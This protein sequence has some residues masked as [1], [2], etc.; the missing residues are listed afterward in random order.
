MKR[1]TL[2]SFILCGLMIQN[3]SNAQQ[4]EYY[5]VG[6]TI[7]GRSP[8]YYYQWWSEAW[9]ADTSHRINAQRSYGIRFVESSN[10]FHGEQLQYYY[11][12]TPIQIIGIATSCRT[13]PLHAG[14]VDFN[15]DPLYPEYLRLYDATVDDFVLLEE[16]QFQR[17]TPKRYMNIDIRV[18]PG[19]YND[20]CYIESP[21]TIVTVDIREYYFEK[22]VTVT[23]SFYV[24]H[25]NENSYGYSYDI[26]RETIDIKGITIEPWA[27]AWDESRITRICDH[28]CGSTPNHLKKYR[29]IVWNTQPN[30]PTYGDTIASLSTWK[31][32]EDPYYMV[33]F[34][35]VVID[36]SW[37]IPPFQCPP[38]TNLR[39]AYQ[40]EGR[41]VLYWDAHAD[42]N[43]WQT[44]FGPQGTPPDSCT[45]FNNPI[46]VADIRGLD[47]CT[48]YDAYVRGVCYHDST[49]Y[50]E[51]V[52]PVDIYIC[53]TTGGG[54][55][56]L[57]TVTAM[58]VLTN[59]IPNPAS[60]QAIVYSSFEISRISAFDANGRMVLDSPMSGHTATLN[61][62]D[63]TPGLYIVIV[64]TPT[65]KVAKKLIVK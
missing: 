43:S 46:Q 59:I 60:M 1:I 17:Q 28:F 57:H 19:F 36:S 3:I 4:S 24:G 39:I 25:T 56:S 12:D 23:D 52:G 41:A 35:I 9:L 5:H 40:G 63:W 38:V 2:T 30:S 51:W 8:I 14:F 61:L 13:M 32:K 6:D 11:T 45:L 31:W 62:K 37:I 54:G 15:L 44:C 50:S 53:D 48:H 26:H 21:D 16:V 49:C 7:N 27:L 29:N 33:E 47:S 18:P 10:Y 64:H 34:P 42:Q 20:C 55:D 65:G 58:N 22:P